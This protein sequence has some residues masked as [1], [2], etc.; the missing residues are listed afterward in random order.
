MDG[1]AESR[2]LE[3]RQRRHQHHDDQSHQEYEG[4]PSA[5]GHLLVQGY[6]VRTFQ[7]GKLNPVAD[8]AKILL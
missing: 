4:G 3:L 5:A 6:R 8:F 1:A 7:R 2:H